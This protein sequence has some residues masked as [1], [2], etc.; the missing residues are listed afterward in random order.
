[1]P[2]KNINFEVVE[3]SERKPTVCPRSLDPFYLVYLFSYLVKYHKKW[4]KTSWTYSTYI[5]A[6]TMHNT[7]TRE[8]QTIWVRIRP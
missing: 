7:R 8:F 2:S 5:K 1:M 3:V 6:K 4:A